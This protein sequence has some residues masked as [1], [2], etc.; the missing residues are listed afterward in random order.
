MLALHGHCRMLLVV[1]VDDADVDVDDNEGSVTGSCQR[2]PTRCGL[3]LCIL[4]DL[5]TQSSVESAR[6][7]CS[8]VLPGV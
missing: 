7:C 4:L 8:N 6:H 5:W 3:S 1:V 2:W